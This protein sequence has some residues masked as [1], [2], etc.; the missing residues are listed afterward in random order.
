M[1][2]FQN[3]KSILFLQKMIYLYMCFNE[4]IVSGERERIYIMKEAVNKKFDVAS[5]TA[6]KGI[7]I[8]MMMLHHC[9]RQASLYDDYT[10]SFQPFSEQFVGNIALIGKI[11][12]S[13]FA[14]ITG[15]GL[16]LNYKK[17]KT[18]VQKWVLI[19]EIKVL[20]GYW[21]IWIVSGVFCQLMNQ[22]T[23]DV[24]FED[25]FWNG[26]VNA[27]V[28]FF[29]G[30]AL[31]GTKT[32]NGTWWY[33]SAAIVFVLLIPVIVAM[34]DYLFLVLMSVVALPRILGLEFLGNN[35]IYVFLT[36]LLLGVMSSKY[37]WMNRFIHWG[38]GTYKKWFKLF[39]MLVAL[40][41]SYKLY[42]ILPTKQFWEVKWGLIPFIVILFCS[43]FIIYLPILRPI[44]IFFGKHSMNIF[45]IHTF[46]RGYYFADFTY[47]FGH[48]SLIVLV[49]LLIS[50]G[51]SICI[52]LMKKTIR[53]QE[54]IQ[55]I[56]KKIEDY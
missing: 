53:Y 16:Y 55:M 51:V 49:L 24:Y 50:T 20:S 45:M 3:K 18:T 12:V 43:E 30:A 22:R 27:F 6:I 4:T 25:G 33:M 36:P 41:A 2:K 56:T 40:F 34:E 52:D 54:F 8:I 5:S 19:R 44:L 11:C 28:D 48:F 35:S 39:V 38:D 31:F 10:V 23:M 32:L 42:I 26:V 21:F 15:Y 37:D 17:N 1:K 47:S 14:F 46:I 29:G 13:L 7:A 9:F